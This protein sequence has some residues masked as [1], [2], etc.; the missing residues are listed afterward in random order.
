VT[1][2]RQDPPFGGPDDDGQD[3]PTDDFDVPLRGWIDPEDRLWRHPS[4]IAPQGQGAQFDSPAPSLLHHH[5]STAMVLVGAG[6]VLAAMAWVVILLS[7]SSDRPMVSDG[8]GAMTD[9]PLTTLASNRETIPNAASAA[10]QSLVQLRASTSHGV[11]SLV[12][13]AVAEGGLVA[14]TASS[15]NGLRSIDMVGS[16]GKLLRSSVVGVDRDSDVAL[17]NVPDDVPVAPF[18]DDNSLGTGSGD[19]TLSMTPVVLPTRCSAPREP[20]R[21]LASPSPVEKPAAC[22]PSPR[23]RQCR[24][25]SRGTRC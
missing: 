23:R 22:P 15:L 17:V 3:G 5:R 6:A 16:D 2:S 8:G 11:V 24:R 10:G 18:A 9:A 25:W 20:S 14:T 12:G 21:P 7:P 1:P 4:E 13:V 19:M